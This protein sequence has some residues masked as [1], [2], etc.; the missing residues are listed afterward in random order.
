VQQTL[1]VPEPT[2]PAENTVDA[3]AVPPSEPLVFSDLSTDHWGKPYIDALTAQGILAGFPDGTF[4]PDQAMTRAEFA[5][6]LAE[7]FDLSAQAE[8]PAF[9]DLPA[10]HWAADGIQAAVRT[11]F[12]QGYPNAVFQPE[13]M[14]PRAQ[15]MAAIAA[16][17]Q[18]SKPTDRTALLSQ[19]P[20]QTQIPE[21]AQSPVAAAIAVGI[22]APSQTKLR[23]NQAATR[24]E[25]ATMIHRALVYLGELPPVE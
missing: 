10:Q 8:T 19:Y 23:P 24:A 13:Q 1:T 15:V 20:D 22:A 16:G 25:V 2:V 4:G 17:L 21:W 6:Q 9:I 3:L 18:L 14:V 5:A 12:M 11:G 7:A